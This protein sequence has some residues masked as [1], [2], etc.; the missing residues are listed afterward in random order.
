MFYCVLAVRCQLKLYSKLI[1]Q[2]RQETWGIVLSLKC[3]L[4][5]GHGMIKHSEVFQYIQ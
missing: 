4:G 1:S 2:V 3:S 5:S